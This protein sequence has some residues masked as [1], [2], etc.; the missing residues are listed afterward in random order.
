MSNRGIAKITGNLFSPS[1][2]RARLAIFC[3]HQVLDAPDEFRAGEPTEEEFAQDIELIS[4][5]FT[6]LPF[7]EVAMRLVSN[8]LP[9]RAACITFDDGYENN[10]S[11]AAPI[12]E[13]AGV[14]ATFF[15]AGGAVDEGIM[16]NDLVIDA[17]AHSGGAPIVDDE[18]SFLERSSPGTTVSDTV[19]SF[20]SQLK[21]KPINE[22]W[23][24]SRRLYFDNVRDDI[25]RLMMTREMVG[26]LST[27]GFDIG[28]HTI[29]HPILKELSDEEARVEIRDCRDWVQTV[30]GSAPLSFA[31][32]N[33]KTGIDFDDRHVK[34]V[35][36]AGF[37]A[38]ASTDW[39]LVKGTTN[40]FNLPRIGPW[41]RQGHG[42]ESGLLRS[43]IRS[44]I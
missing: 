32:P 22:R 14:P 16:W 35:A 39:N 21:Y 33:G 18:I 13:K 26:D 19:L 44:Y 43:Y 12:L 30:T 31:Y 27:R 9:K 1:G 15:I 7:G 24:I 20:L 34:M 10:H 28:G 25:P 41:W 42:L 11:L 3:Y 38:A 23:E 4:D 6:V 17:I 36:D 2:Q 29:N 8:T 40:P 37:S 5:V